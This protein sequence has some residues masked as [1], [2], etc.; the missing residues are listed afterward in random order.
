M[1]GMHINT[2][3][4]TVTHTDRLHSVSHSA[5]SVHSAQNEK[6]FTNRIDEQMHKPPEAE[7]SA[8]PKNHLHAMQEKRG[9]KK[10]D[11]SDGNF[12]EGKK[13]KSEKKRKNISYN[14]IDCSA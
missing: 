12:S 8:E 7:G 2:S 11:K 14:G 1:T 10:R 13:R 5:P 3:V 6:H 4:N 9:R